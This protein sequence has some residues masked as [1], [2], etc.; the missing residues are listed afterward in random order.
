MKTTVIL[1]VLGYACLVGAALMA[2]KRHWDRLKRD[3]IPGL[4]QAPCEN[5]TH[6][7]E[8]TSTD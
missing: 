2:N 6:E 7:H 5:G 4:D 8:D 1:F 3:A